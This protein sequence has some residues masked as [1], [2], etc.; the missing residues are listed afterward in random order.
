MGIGAQSWHCQSDGIITKR[1][2]QPSLELRNTLFEI[3]FWFSVYASQE[4][5]HNQ[6][7]STCCLYWWFTSHVQQTAAIALGLLVCF[8]CVHACISIVQVWPRVAM[9]PRWMLWDEF[10]RTRP[11]S[12]RLRSFIF[13]GGANQTI[14]MHIVNKSVAWT[15]TKLLCWRLQEWA[16]SLSTKRT[17]MMKMQ[18]K[19]YRTRLRLMQ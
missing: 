16:K 11:S 14:S 1:K 19:M 12:C 10:N 6:G 5:Y 7:T 15:N 9:M 2:G 17:E 18:Q 13:G 4:I 3:K 8:V